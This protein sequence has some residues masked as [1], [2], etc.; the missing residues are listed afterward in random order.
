VVGLETVVQW[1]A[2]KF[3]AKDP[4][5]VNERELKPTKRLCLQLPRGNLLEIDSLFMFV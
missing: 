2:L 1:V 3:Q 5:F 4:V